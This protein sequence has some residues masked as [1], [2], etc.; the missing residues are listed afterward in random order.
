MRLLIEID[1]R[2]KKLFYDLAKLTNSTIIEEEPEL[3]MD[4]PEHVR[5]EIEKGLEQARTD[6]TKTYKEVKKILAER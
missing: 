4:F 5:L 1:E 2:Y 3:W 6:Q